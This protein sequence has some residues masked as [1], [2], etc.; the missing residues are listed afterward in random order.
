M[1]NILAL[2]VQV[3][4]AVLLVATIIYAYMLNRKLTNLRQDQAQFEQLIRQF[5]GALGMADSGVHN[6]RVAAEEAGNGLQKYVDRAQILRDELA[7]MLES[8]D[9][10]AEQLANQIRDNRQNLR[11]KQE[12]KRLA[13][14]SATAASSGVATTGAAKAVVATKPA[15]ASMTQAEKLASEIIAE[16]DRES[17]RSSAN[18]L[19]LTPQ[20]AESLPSTSVET[21][22]NRERSILSAIKGLR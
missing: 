21:A 4:V 22:P 2:L 19:P 5:T 3:T 15:A 20:S 11:D 14:V 12:D 7:Y 6:L 17:G 10:L 16:M 8:G 13:D 18:K 1:F 9:A